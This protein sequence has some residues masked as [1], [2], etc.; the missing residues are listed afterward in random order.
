MLPRR[1]V[2]R[3]EQALRIHA[4]ADHDGHSTKLVSRVGVGLLI[5]HLVGGVQKL[6]LQLHRGICC[7]ITASI[8]DDRLIVI[9]VGRQVGLLGRQV[10]QGYENG[11]EKED[12][13][14]GKRI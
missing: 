13:F 4:G 8:A 6:K 14:H 3:I 2:Q 5:L 10:Q 7:H 9:A 11:Y 1:P 12:F